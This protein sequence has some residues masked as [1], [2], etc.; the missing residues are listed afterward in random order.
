MSTSNPT[1]FDF[2]DSTP[3]EY[4]VCHRGQ[5]YILTE[6]SEA[7]AINFRNAS[8]KGANFV[9][10]DGKPSSAKMEGGAEA[11]VILVAGCLYQATSDNNAPPHLK[12]K[13]GKGWQ[14]KRDKNKDGIHVPPNELRGWGSKVIK[15]LFEK[16]KEIGD[17]NEGKEEQVKSNTL[18]NHDDPSNPD[19][20]T[21]G[22]NGF[23]P[24][25][26]ESPKA[27]THS[28]TSSP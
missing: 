20:H 23:T 28:M 15:P 3:Q 27:Q 14:I 24:E 21:N 11:Q 5:R 13:D 19:E 4:L 1:M 6:P 10:K 9:M 8:L 16:C 25:D 18:T 17:L 7:A 12:D 22:V 26:N 2:D